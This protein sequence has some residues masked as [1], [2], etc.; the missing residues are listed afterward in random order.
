M[1]RSVRSNE[2][3]IPRSKHLDDNA[4][5]LRASSKQ[6]SSQPLPEVW[7]PP[8][9]CTE[10][11]KTAVASKAELRRVTCELMGLSSSESSPELG[12]SGG[13]VGLG[14]SNVRGLSAGSVGCW[15]A[16]K[17]RSIPASKEGI[18]RD[19]S[20][21]LGGASGKLRPQRRRILR[22]DIDREIY[23]SPYVRAMQGEGETSPGVMQAHR[24]MTPETPH[25]TCSSPVASTPRLANHE[26]MAIISPVVKTGWQSTSRRL[27]RRADVHTMAAAVDV[28]M[29]RSRFPSISGDTTKRAPSNMI[30]TKPGGL[31]T[32]LDR[33]SHSK[34]AYAID[35]QN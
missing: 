1:R 6:S 25:S 31:T 32:Q 12:R 33:L 7:K 11:L 22:D 28:V 29:K 35:C 13:S 10:A 26:G 5:V 34:L 30:S 21:S 17:N 27:E 8:W 15:A 23:G 18:C 4:S 20:A 3:P 19:R 14:G 16:S 9:G 24:C 2:T